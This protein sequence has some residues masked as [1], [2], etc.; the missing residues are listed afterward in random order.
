[1]FREQLHPVPVAEMAQV[2]QWIADLDSPE[3][4]VREKAMRE[5]ERRVEAVEGALRKVLESR[6]SLEVRQ[7]VRL[8][9]DKRDLTRMD[10]QELRIL[11]QSLRAVEVLEHLDTAGARRLLK[12]LAS[13][14]AEARLTQE[15]TAALARLAMRSAVR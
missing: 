2:R 6:P 12:T 13:G 9:L 11:L 3:F 10:R 5:L 4:A 8:L 1:M 7:R 14:A 15:A